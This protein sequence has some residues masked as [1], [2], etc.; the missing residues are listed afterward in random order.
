MRM[1]LS[2]FYVIYVLLGPPLSVAYIPSESLVEGTDFY[3]SVRLSK[4]GEYVYFSLLS[5]G[6]H[7]VSP[8]ADPVHAAVVSESFYE[9]QSCYV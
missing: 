8:C 4:G 9:H 2:S 1:P 3:F 6:T 5:L 7:V